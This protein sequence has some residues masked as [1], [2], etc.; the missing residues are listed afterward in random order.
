[1]FCDPNEIDEVWRVGTS[2]GCLNPRHNTWNHLIKRKALT[3]LVAGATAKNE[4]GIATKVAPDNGDPGRP[5]R[6]ICIYTKDFKDMEDVARVARKMRDIGLIEARGRP[7]YYKCG[8]SIST[9]ALFIFTDPMIDAYTYL[10][11]TSDNQWGIKA[12]LYASNDVLAAQGDK[13]KL[14]GILNKKKKDAGDW[15]E[16]EG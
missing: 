4:L 12:S 14:E 15:H 6:L 5:H 10:G 2:M 16:A 11:L 9:L 3:F 1:M 7:I 13:K 8:Q